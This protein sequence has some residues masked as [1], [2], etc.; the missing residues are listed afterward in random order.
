MIR[1]YYFIRIKIYILR[2][3][4]NVNFQVLL[5]AMFRRNPLSGFREILVSAS[6]LFAL[7]WIKHDTFLSSLLIM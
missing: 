4:E 1:A 6:V 7:S 3:K 5:S 2:S